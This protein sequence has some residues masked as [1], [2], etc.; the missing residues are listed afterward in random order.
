MTT[1]PIAR[2]S[3]AV[4]TLS[5][6]FAIALLEGLDLQSVGVAAPRMAR[7]FGLSV[8]QMGLAFSAGT[9]GLLPGAM[10]G[11]RLADRIG[12]KRVLILS[13]CV[14][15]LLSIATALVSS[16]NMLVLVR[17]LTGIG[18]GGA[19]PNLIA[20]SSE[21]VSNKARNTAVSVMYCGI[22]FGGVIAS[23][24]GIVEH[25]RYRL[26]PYLLRGRRRTADT[27]AASLRVPAGVEGV[28]PR[29]AWWKCPARARRSSALRR[30]SRPFHAADLDQLLLHADRPVLPP[31][32]AA[33]ADG[34]ARSCARR[35]RLCA[36]LL[37]HWR[38]TSARCASE[39]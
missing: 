5:L 25:G 8:A 4:V 34:R 13:A 36:D 30:E 31:Q 20:L 28:Q 29:V 38:R 18:L 21:A 24:I 10:F 33:L 23:I 15:G 1:Q 6:C 17:V 3:A 26:A 11:G 32:L 9:F 2:S 27:R 19:L 22:P 39:C 7:E 37:Q 35:S 16:F 12:R 14:F